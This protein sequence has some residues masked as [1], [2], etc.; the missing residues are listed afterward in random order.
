MSRRKKG[1]VIAIN[2]VEVN[3]D[4]EN[5]VDSDLVVY[6]KY[7]GPREALSWQRMM[8]RVSLEERKRITA[9]RKDISAEVSPE[10]Y[11]TD[12][13]PFQT[14]EGSQA[15]IEVS[16]AIFKEAFSHATGMD[17]ES[18][19]KAHQEAEL[20]ELGVPLFILRAVQEAQAPKPVHFPASPSTGDPQPE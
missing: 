12:A 2:V 10:L 4:A 11:D 9:L 8:Q 13:H 6:V 20:I 7:V 14:P 17:L 3:S 1:D 16:E 15:I 5:Y 19:D 18:M